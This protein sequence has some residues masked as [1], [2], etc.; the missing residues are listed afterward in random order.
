MKKKKLIAARY[1]KGEI[2]RY[3][4]IK[5]NPNGSL[6][7]IAGITD[8]SGRV[9]GMMPHPERAINFTQLPDWT[10]LKEKYKREGKEVPKEGPGMKIFKNAVKYFK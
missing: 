3:Q 10:L 4:N 9:I 1:V 7:N 2:C 8:E 5:P 6:E